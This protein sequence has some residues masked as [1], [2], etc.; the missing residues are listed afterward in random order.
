MEPA[1]LEPSELSRRCVV[2]EVWGILHADVFSTQ[3]ISLVL[4]WHALPTG[5][6]FI[7]IFLIHSLFYRVLLQTLFFSFLKGKQGLHFLGQFQSRE[8]LFCCFNKGVS[9]YLY[10]QSPG[11][12]NVS[13][14]LHTAGCSYLQLP[15]PQMGKDWVGKRGIQKVQKVQLLFALMCINSG[16]PRT[17]SCGIKVCPDGAVFSLFSYD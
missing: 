13:S 11:Y 17:N 10:I 14:K 4:L 2:L 6:V 5:E 7:F 3:F 16:G 12:N 15:Y 8:F 9:V 1:F